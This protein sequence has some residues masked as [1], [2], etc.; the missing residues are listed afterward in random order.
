LCLANALELLN[1]LLQIPHRITDLLEPAVTVVIDD[2]DLDSRSLLDDDDDSELDDTSSASV[3][4]G[5]L[6]PV[7]VH[8]TI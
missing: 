6:S 2:D 4:A 3:G 7:P 1:V 5:S 8:S